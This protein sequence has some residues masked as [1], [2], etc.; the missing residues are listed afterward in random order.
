MNSEKLLI[1]GCGD[2]GRRLAQRVK[3]DFS[4]IIGLRRSPAVPDEAGG[5]SRYIALDVTQTGAFSALETL[6]PDVVVIT[7]TPS[8]YTD[9]GYQRAYVDSCK[10]VC[11]FLK[12]R[13]APPR[14]VVFVSSTRVYAQQ[15]GERVDEQSPTAPTGFPGTRMLDAES[16][17]RN[18]GL[19]H[20]IVRF[21]GIYGPG[22]SRMIEQ[23]RDG[24]VAR[25]NVI[26]NRIHAD[27]CAGVI[28]HLIRRHKEG[29]PCLPVYLASDSAPVFLAEVTSW[30]AGQ[31]KVEAPTYNV[32][33]EAAPGKYCNNAALLATGFQFRYPDY[34]SG[35]RALLSA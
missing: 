10:Q 20:I 30:L 16:V 2:L 24:S 31:L 19:P 27:D 11:A 7:M 8:A 23:V 26:T 6:S 5:V 3:T 1:V 4:D 21:S 17:I 18:S 22:R 33:S 34:R 13:A 28:A 25:Q 14:L 32:A 15:A 29:L 12:S 9:E 35:Y